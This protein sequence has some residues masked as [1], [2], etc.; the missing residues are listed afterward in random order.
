MLTH[1][2]QRPICAGVNWLETTI[3][4]NNHASNSLFERFATQHQAELQQRVLFESQQH[5]GGAHDS[6]LLTRIGPLHL[7]KAA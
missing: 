7:A 6:E 2:I 1:I 3:T 4:E 5:F